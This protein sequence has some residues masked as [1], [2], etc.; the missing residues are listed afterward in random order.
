[1]TKKP[2]KKCTDCGKRRV[3]TKYYHS[4]NAPD[5]RAPV[6][7]DCSRLRSRVTNLA[8]AALRDRH[9]G[10][11]LELRTELTKKLSVTAADEGDR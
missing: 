7:V 1:M 4:K 5:G 2:T 11:Y 3:L 8:L 9:R 6:C 10:E